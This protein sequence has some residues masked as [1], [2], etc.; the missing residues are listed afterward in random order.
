MILQKFSVPA[1]VPAWFGSLG[2]AAS[3]LGASSGAS[4][5]VKVRNCIVHPKQ[6]KRGKVSA[7]GVNARIEV[8]TLGIW[9]LEL[10]LLHLV[11]YNGTYYSRLKLG[12]YDGIREVVPWK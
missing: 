5:L 11:G 2:H 1:I 10:S 7:I 4:A 9:F 6:S 8:L 3:S 12:S